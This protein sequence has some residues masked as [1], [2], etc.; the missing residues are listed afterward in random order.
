LPTRRHK[1]LRD[2]LP[3]EQKA[4]MQLSAILRLANALDAGH[5]GHIRRIR[6][7]S[8]QINAGKSRQKREGG[9]LRKLAAPDRNQPLIIIAE[10]YTPFGSAARSIAAER[11]LLETLLRRPVVVR[12]MTQPIRSD[13]RQIR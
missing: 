3:D 11:H 4:T 1:L 5:D 6:L 12:Q 13:S 8:G 7:E 2:L 10:G 9:F